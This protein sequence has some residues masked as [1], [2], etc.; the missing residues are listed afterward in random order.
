MSLAF[1]EKSKNI[2]MDASNGLS[3]WRAFLNAFAP[4]YF[5]SFSLLRCYVETA[6]L[7]DQEKKCFCENIC[8]VHKNLPLIINPLIINLAP[9]IGI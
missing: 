9:V 4:I 1:K 7:A 3:N 6:I 2:T 8:I 5:L